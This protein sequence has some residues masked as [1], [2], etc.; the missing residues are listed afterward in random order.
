MSVLVFV[1]MVD[2]PPDE[3][4]KPARVLMDL[5][6][7]FTRA[8]PQMIADQWK[9]HGCVNVPD[10]LPSFVRMVESDTP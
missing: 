6:I 7:S 8:E 4:R 10:D 9:F 2:F 5:G 1:D 3:T